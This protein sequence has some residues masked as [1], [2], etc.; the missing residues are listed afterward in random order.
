MAES[1]LHGHHSVPISP[2]VPEQIPGLLEKVCSLG[3]SV[4]LTNAKERSALLE[5]V[6]SLMYV[7][8]TPREA[9]T[10]QCWSAVCPSPCL[11]LYR[12]L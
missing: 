4:D 12:Q 1:E 8:E 5:T 11:T 7:L 10:R 9:M 3:K 6:R 2:N